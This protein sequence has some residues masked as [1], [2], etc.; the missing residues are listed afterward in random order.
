MR[1]ILTG[2]SRGLG[3]GICGALLEAGASVLALSRHGNDGLAARYGERLRQIPIDLG[4]SHRL[5]ALTANGE[6]KTFLAGDESMLLVNNAGA[7]EPIGPVGHQGGDAIARAIGVNVTAALI[8]SD[9]FVSATGAAGDRRLLHVSSGAARAAYAGWS[10]YCASKAALDHH[11]R[12]L[13]LDEI[14]G[15]RV[16]SVA[17]GVIDTG[18]QTLIRSSTS[19]DFPA[20]ERFRALH[21]HGQLQSPDECGRR[22]VGFL[23]S[24]TFGQQVIADIRDL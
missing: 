12:A 3:A 6:W 21:R 22:L 1:A 23:L 13:D 24:P 16:A 10:V 9:A 4:D 18:M 19:A 7:L 11:A 20:I 2:H 17:P 5:A 14:P 8:L 15:L